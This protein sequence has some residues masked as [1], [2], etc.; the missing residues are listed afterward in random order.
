[1]WLRLV[2]C[3]MY[4]YKFGIRCMI[5]MP[6]GMLVSSHCNGWTVTWIHVKY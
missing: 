2:I 6:Y 1:M 5:R 4:L 3:I